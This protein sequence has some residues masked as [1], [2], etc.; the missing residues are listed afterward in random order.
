VITVDGNR[1]RWS[2]R[3]QPTYTQAIGDAGIHVAVALEDGV[4]A[5]LVICFDG[6]RPDAWVRP[7]E[8]TIVTPAVVAEAVRVAQRRGWVANAPG[9]AFTLS[10]A[11]PG[12][13][14]A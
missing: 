4:G 1:Y 6:V 9:P 7:V 3:P 12:G 11:S 10:I 5:T 2:I 14:D 13:G 8:G